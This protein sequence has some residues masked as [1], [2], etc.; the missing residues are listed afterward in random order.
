MNA[1][2]EPTLDCTLFAV[3]VPAD[4]VIAL[5]ADLL[6]AGVSVADFSLCMVDRCAAAAALSF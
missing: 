1:H 3:A 2:P 5:R 6:S 4:E